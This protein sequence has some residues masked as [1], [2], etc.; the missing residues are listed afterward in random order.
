MKVLVVGG[1]GREHALV[2]KIAQSPRVKAIYCAPGN[3]GI[4]RHAR[5]VPISAGDVEGL[6][7]LAR[8]EGIDLT[9]VGPEEPL[10]KGIADRFEAEGMALF[11][12]SAM[13]ARLEGSKAFA[14]ELMARHGIPTAAFEAF[15]S[16]RDAEAYIRKVGAPVVVKA[17]GLAAGKGVFPCRSTEEA[18]R[19][20]NT[21]MVERAFGEAGNRVVVEEF[22]GGEEASFLAITDGE[23]VVA[24]P[25]AQDHKAAW[26]GD[27][28][29]NTG[30]MGAYS[31]APIVTQALHRQVMERIMIPTVRAMAREGCPFRGVLYAG[32]MIE[33]DEAKVLEF[34]V[35]LGDPEAQPLLM[36]LRGDLVSVLEAALRG[37]LRSSDLQWDPGAAVCVVMASRGYPGPYEKGRPISGLQAAGSH[38]GVMV[39]HAGTRE[40][41]GR[42]VTDGGRVLGVTAVGADVQD[43][44]ERAYA[45]VGEISWEGVHFRRD[46]G[47][48]ALLR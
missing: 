26:D 3:A 42:V 34:N 23:R 11:G 39:F 29:P 45:A 31:P 5:C 43:A 17:D 36:R 15:S 8:D 12:V 25:S 32:L 20:L 22:L 38:E 4:A 2:W 10:V 35:R 6:A 46:I 30:G 28:G 9:V 1:G 13:A 40:V 14:K 33:G 27:R 7:A 44:V 37:D 16:L 21:I 24:L 18:L 48:R 47:H 19:A 41:D